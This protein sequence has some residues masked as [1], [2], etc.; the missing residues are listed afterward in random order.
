MCVT[1]LACQKRILKQPPAATPKALPA[2]ALALLVAPLG[3]PR[4]QPEHAGIPREL[5]Q[6]WTARRAAG[7]P[8]G[9]CTAPSAAVSAD[10]RRPA[11]RGCDARA[12]GGSVLHARARS[13]GD[14][15][16]SCRKKQLLPA[17][18]A[19][20]SMEQHTQGGSCA[21][22]VPDVQLC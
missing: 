17:A 7:R 10:S 5:T 16:R 19:A 13:E 9:R 14:C 18:A 4:M 12:N 6:W 2:A 20:L 8:A 1:C 15:A 3:S 22:E 11:G 21:L